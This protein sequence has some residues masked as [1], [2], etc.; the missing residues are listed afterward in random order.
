MLWW[1]TNKIWSSIVQC[2]FSI[3]PS[4]LLFLF[5]L[6]SVE[7]CTWFNHMFRIFSFYHFRSIGKHSF[8]RGIKKLSSDR[9]GK[10]GGWMYFFFILYFVLERKL[11][12]KCDWNWAW[13]TAFLM[14][15]NEDEATATA[16]STTMTINVCEYWRESANEQMSNDLN[17][18]TVLLFWKSIH[19]MN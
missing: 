7:K 18:S 10:T 1:Y 16:T 9:D 19:I 12:I 15:Q 5:I 3:L 4:T 14:V 17:K 11:E 6:R 2:T 8:K 13:E